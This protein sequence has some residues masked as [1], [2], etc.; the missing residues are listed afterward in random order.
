MRL[1]K[2]SLSGPGGAPKRRSRSMPKVETGARIP[3]GVEVPRLPG[4]GRGGPDKRDR[5]GV[6]RRRLGIVGVVLGAL[7]VAG[8]PSPSR[9]G[10]DPGPAGATYLALGDSLAYGMQVGKLRSQIAAGS[11]Q[12]S[13]FSGYVDVLAANLRA[14]TPGLRVFNLGC[15]GETTTSFIEG[16]CAYGTTGQPFGATPLPLH[17]GYAG[18]QLAAALDHLSRHRGEVGVITL[19]IGI[20]DLRAVALACPAGADLA[21]CMAD[22]WP[23]ALERTAANLR[24]ILVRLRA[25][26]P[27]ATILVPTYYNWLAVTDPATNQSVE[28]LNRAI[29]AAAAEAGA[30]VVDTF[31]A[32]NRT[33]DERERLCELTLFCG[34]TR[35]LHP[36]D[37]G[38]RAIGELLAAA[39]R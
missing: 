33:G 26:A 4:A 28:Q 25:A 10:P 13:S 5:S 29:A 34:P 12:A 24:A 9:A 37:A 35:D 31:A 6:G 3:R 1:S 39:A 18:A 11:V 32:F 27:A 38:Y 22:R 30:R 14:A 16:P 21:R 7:L 19:T 8:T 15:P 17:V 23:A 20:N 36:S 2:R